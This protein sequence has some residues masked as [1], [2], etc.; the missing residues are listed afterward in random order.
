M[1]ITAKFASTCHC[2]LKPISVGS[3]V[4]WSKG[5]KAKHV[6]CSGASVASTTG[7][8]RPYN[9]DLAIARRN[10]AQTGDYYGSGLYDEES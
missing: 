1:I 6:T 2:C 3:K 7:G 10:Y 5:S 4:E 8:R 9:R